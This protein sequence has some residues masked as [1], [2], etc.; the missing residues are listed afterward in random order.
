MH[1][2]AANTDHFSNPKK[3]YGI[4]LQDLFHIE[5][6]FSLHYFEYMSTFSFPGESHD[7]WEFVCV[8]K[9]EVEIGA[10]PLTHTLRRGE[11]AF[12]YPGEFHWVK[13]NGKI[14]PNLIVISFSCTDP[15]MEFFR[16]KILHLEETERRLLA[17]IIAIRKM[18]IRAMQETYLTAA[19]EMLYPEN[20]SYL[21]DILSYE[22]IGARSVENQQHR[23]TASGMDIPIGMKNP[24]SGDLSVMLNS[25]VAAQGPHRFI[26]RGQDVT[27]GGNDLAHVI[28]RG[29]VDKYGTTIPNYHYEDC[30]RLLDMYEQKNLKNPA[31]II[32]AN[33]SN[34]NKQYKEQLRIVSE[35]L[36]TRN[37]DSKL[38]KLIKGVMVES[39]LVEGRQ[40]IGGN[41]VYGK[42]ITDP[43]IGW[44]DTVR[45]ID[46]IAEEC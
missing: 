4:Q 38:K 17:G 19:D 31:A 46:K 1:I 12:H 18:H 40:D 23:L 10:G 24:T 41:M 16:G 29:G 30:K 35:V 26:Y 2:V 27:T 14:A 21:D 15:A 9:G 44:E 39:Y 34:S 11:I 45:L 3:Y 43:C 20:R 25:V 37:Y 36:H 22:A 13:A 6:L 42:S 32:D 5:E 8:D 28:L 7:F 33:H